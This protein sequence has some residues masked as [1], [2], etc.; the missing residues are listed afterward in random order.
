MTRPLKRRPCRFS[1]PGAAQRRRARARHFLA[2]GFERTEPAVLQPAALFLD[3]SGEEIRGRLF[4][5]ADAAG[6]EMCLRPEYTIPVCRAIW[7]GRAGGRRIFL[8]RPRV[9]ARAGRTASRRRP[10][11][12]VSAARTRKRRMR[13]CSRSAS[14][15]RRR[16]EAARSPPGSATPA[17]SRPCFTRSRFPT[18]GGGGCAAALP[19]GA[20]STQS[21]NRPARRAGAA[22]VLAALES[23]DH[24]GA[25]ALVEDLLAIAGIEA[26]GGRSASE[27]AD[28]FLEQARCA[29]ASR[30]RPR[31]WRCCEAFLAISGDPDAGRD[32]ASAPG[33]GRGPRPRGGARRL[34]D[35]QR[36]HR[37]A[38]RRRSSDPLQRRLRARLRLLHRLRVRGHDPPTLRRK[39]RARRRPLRRARAPARRGRGHA[40]R[41]RR[42]HARPARNGGSA[43][44]RLRQW[45]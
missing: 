42:D 41:R 17:C 32:R 28:R 8:S 24:A 19:T 20:A 38:R 33:Q 6:E 31:S 7:L 37:R 44:G 18:S 26:V 2:A 35:A 45:R 10:G 27:I 23:A 15:R 40:R 36:L 12:K 13:K 22:G 9:S 3:M 43:D 14:R 30:S 21:S 11:S 4:L 29:R 1:E 25:K 5:T 34:R 39:A 16:R